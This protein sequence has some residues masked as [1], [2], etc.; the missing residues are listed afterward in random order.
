[1]KLERAIDWLVEPRLPHH[2]PLW[3]WRQRQFERPG[4]AAPN[5]RGPVSLV[6][7]FDV[8]QTTGCY[9]TVGSWDTCEPFLDWLGEASARRGWRTTMF[10]QGSIVKPLADRLRPFLSDHELGLHGYFHEVWGRGLWF[11]DQPGTPLHLRRR[12]LA[13]GL[14]AFA[15]AGLPRPRSFRA[16]YLV[17]DDDTLDLLAEHGFLLDSSAPA[18]RGCPPVVSRRGSLVRI[19]VSAAYRPRIR[20]RWGIPTWAPFELLNLRTVLFTPPDRLLA[21]V[22]EILAFQAAAGSPPHLVILAHPWE[23]SDGISPESGPGNYARLEERIDFLSAELPIRL[24]TLA[25]VAG[26]EE[27]AHAVA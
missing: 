18:F 16:P 20:R 4:G 23:F 10:V 12:L 17:A 13:E 27:A 24:T 2:A 25:N 11:G 3:W 6:L 1:M 22:R 9:G 15:D 21:I 8:E 7:S 5:D 19:P 26:V 14:Q